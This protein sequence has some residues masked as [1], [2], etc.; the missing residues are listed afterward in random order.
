MR[1]IK[2]FAS[3]VLSSRVCPDELVIKNCADLFMKVTHQ[4]FQDYLLPAML[5]ALLRNP[6][7]L[8]KSEY[9]NLLFKF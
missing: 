1:V 3:S 2:L 7:E 5:K 9:L 4:I 6:E 8:I